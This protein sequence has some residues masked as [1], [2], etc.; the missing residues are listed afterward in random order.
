MHTSHYGEERNRLKNEN[1]NVL[2]LLVNECSKAFNGELLE[3]L[4]TVNP[5]DGAG[6]VSH[7][8]THHP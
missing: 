6:I 2:S 1:I 4:K 8:I 3:H 5:I 7:T